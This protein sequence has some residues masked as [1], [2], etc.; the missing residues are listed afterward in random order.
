MLPVWLPRRIPST[1]WAWRHRTSGTGRSSP[2]SGPKFPVRPSRCHDPGCPAARGAGQ[3]IIPGSVSIPWMSSALA[4]VNFRKNAK[5]WCPARPANALLRLPPAL[6]ARLP[7]PQSLRRLAHV[8]RSHTGWSRTLRLHAGWEA[9]SPPTPNH[10][11]ASFL[12]PSRG[13]LVESSGARAACRPSGMGKPLLDFTAPQDSPLSIRDGKASFA[14]HS[15]SVN[16]FNPG[17]VNS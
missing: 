7:R 9:A 8:G 12:N 13:R 10:R 14:L 6:P 16:R 15:P 5:S 3:G 2:R 1:S 11:T 4:W 17:T